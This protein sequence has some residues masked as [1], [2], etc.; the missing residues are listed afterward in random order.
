MNVTFLTYLALVAFAANSVL[1]KF[2]LAQG[3]I[4]PE[5]FIA[6]RLFAGAV[7][8]VL[9]TAF[10]RGLRRLPTFQNPISA[11]ALLFYAV[12]FSFAYITLDT[13][14]GALIL[15]GGVQITMFAGALISGERPHL[16]RWIGTILGMS[17][18]AILFAPGAAAPD[19]IGALLMTIAAI[20]W[21]IYSLR[22]RI[23]SEPLY[24]TAMNFIYAA[25]VGVV[26]WLILPS[27]IP[28]TLNGVLLATASGALASGLGYAIWY[29]VLPKLDSSLAAIL[30]LTVPIIALGGGIL[31]L[32]ESAN[33]GFALASA[34]IFGGVFLAVFSA[35]P[36]RD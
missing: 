4:G 22:G 8:L 35:K 12:A 28:T 29:S 32:G 33:W 25:P 26:L 27:D 11:F 20:S 1:T 13:G 9:L 6:I 23:I 7:T 36:A 15:F 18:L 2:A 24:A 5:A 19:P 14:I 3:Q 21:G 31:F 17:G 10:R 30:Q 34:L 16:F